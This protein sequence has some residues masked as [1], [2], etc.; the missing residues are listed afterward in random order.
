M[1]EKTENIKALIEEL[2]AEESQVLMPYLRSRLPKH[3]LE[4]KWDIG[5]ELILDAIFRSQDITQRGVRG[6]IAEAVFEAK[7]LPKVRG[8]QVVP[9]VGDLTYDFLI[10]R[11]S[12]GRQVRIQVK[13]QRTVKGKPLARRLYGDNSYIVEV[14][15]TRTGKKTTENATGQ[16]KAVQQDTRPYQFGDFDILAVNLHPATRDWTTFMYTVGGWLLPRGENRRLI[17]VMQPVSSKRSDVWT[18]DLREC[19]EWFISGE[20]KLIFDVKA[21]K[22]KLVKARR[23]MRNLTERVR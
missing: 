6:V 12:D 1:S 23:T 8:W 2:S 15:K 7:V 16:S 13:L 9:V 22:E 20:K 5:Y 14:Q 17:Q 21:A 18:N 10:K 4:Q 3:A 19:I 11:K